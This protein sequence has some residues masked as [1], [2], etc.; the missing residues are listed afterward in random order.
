MTEKN[1]DDKDPSFLQ[2]VFSVLAAGFGVRSSKN[3]DKDFNGGNLKVIIFAGLVGV[4]IFIS[5]LV[6]VVSFVVGQ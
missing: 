6:T 4:V 5:T 1:G 2:L 3:Q